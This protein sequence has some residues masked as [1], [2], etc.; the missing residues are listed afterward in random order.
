MRSRASIRT[1]TRPRLP[2]SRAR[3]G[4]C[5]RRATQSRSSARPRRRSITSSRRAKSRRRSSSRARSRARITA[6]N[7]APGLLEQPGNAP[8]PYSVADL[9]TMWMLADVPESDSPDLKLGQPV[10]VSVIA[11]PGRV[12][13]G[14]ITAI[15]AT[16][17]PEF[18]PSHGAL[19]DQ[20]SDAR[21]ASLKCSPHSSF[22]RA[23][24]VHAPAV[25]LDGVVREGDG[26]MSVW[27]V[28]SDPHRFTRRTVKIGRQQDGYDEI[29]EGV[30]PGREGRSRRRDLP[31]ATS[32]TAARPDLALRDER[33]F[34]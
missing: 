34:P 29:L 9:S 33:A 26:T 24:P 8:A 2:T 20:G 6:R 31:A 5:G 28:G 16:V 22:A 17:D 7:A 3:E 25:P 14:K 23:Q 15:G 18:A 19:R 32:S 21:A 10:T 11:L 1:T 30:Q 12:F 27:V 13:A 4:A